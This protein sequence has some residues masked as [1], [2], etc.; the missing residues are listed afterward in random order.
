MDGPESVGDEAYSWRSVFPPLVGLLA[1]NSGFLL[2]PGYWKLLRWQYGQAIPRARINLF[3][4][5]SLFYNLLLVLGCVGSWVFHGILTPI[6]VVPLFGA[7]LSISCVS[8]ESF[9][10]VL[11]GVSACLPSVQTRRYWVSWYFILTAIPFG[12]IALGVD[13]GL[14]SNV[15]QWIFW[16]I[17]DPEFMDHLGRSISELYESLGMLLLTNIGF[18][19]LSG[20]W[21]ASR[22]G[23]TFW[24]LSA[25]YNVALIIWFYLMFKNDPDGCWETLIPGLGV[26]L[27]GLCL[28][29][30]DFVLQ[31]NWLTSERCSINFAGQSM[32][33]LIL[34]LTGSNRAMA[35]LLGI[36]LL[37]LLM[38]VPLNFIG[39]LMQ[40]RMERRNQAIADVNSSWGP[41]Q[42]VIG[43]I[44]EVPVAI[45]GGNNPS[46]VKAYSLPKRL[47][48]DGALA[49]TKRHRGIYDA[50]VYDAKLTFSGE[51][52][53]VDLTGL[54]IPP[55]SVIQ[56]NQAIVHVPISDLRGVEHALQLKCGPDSIDLQPGSG[57]SFFT[58]GL[59]GAVPSL[60]DKQSL[61]F[62]LALNLHGT[63]GISFLPVAMENTVHLVSGWADPGFMGSF[64]PTNQTVSKDG[65]D[66]TW[67]VSFYG[68]NF[69]QAWM[70]VDA[71]AV[72]QE[73]TGAWF[74]VNFVNMVDAYRSVER[75]TKYA[76]LF[77]ALV[78]VTFFLFELISGLNI[79]VVQYMLVGAAL[80]LFYLALLSES[81]FLDFPVAYSVA[82][83]LSVTLIIFYCG[84]VL[85]SWLRSWGLAT[86][87]VTVY[88]LMF[89]VL[90][91]QDYSLL[92]GTAGLFGALGLVMY[93]IRNLDWNELSKPI[94]PTR[95]STGELP[96]IPNYPPV[97]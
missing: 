15:S 67:N 19:F 74:G 7:L 9:K 72:G 87:L 34:F 44:L 60:T 21:K 68:R 97:P 13:Y 86:G 25:L 38:L 48:V 80:V 81:E 11:G 92:V 49:T 26:V 89:V 36:A 66:A 24:L 91:M 20:Y 5:A 85:K 32:T 63:G 30:A 69:P 6:V 8:W 33:P 22:S 93:V 50:V 39:G 55:G 58:S 96:R 73:M 10:E 79:H 65:F 4:L 41:S 78:F 35:K 3:W 1:I 64:L 95:I 18:L 43:P 28:A 57:V 14:V 12:L 51:F 16:E 70:E 45:G 2:L 84:F 71:T 94:E 90:E 88:G 59:H 83:G 23:N 77:F 82:T 42:Q 61:P 75:S 46:I 76:V 56:W 52:A 31:S 27:S 53:P 62:E 37:T 29:G 17:V 47:I 54:A 40:E